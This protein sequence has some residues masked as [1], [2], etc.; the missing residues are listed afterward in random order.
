MY[1]NLVTLLISISVIFCAQQNDARYTSNSWSE[2]I[3]IKNNKTY[4]IYN[5]TNQNINLS[6][7]LDIYR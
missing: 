4:K 6:I 5:P 7:P 1:I 2:D 3:I